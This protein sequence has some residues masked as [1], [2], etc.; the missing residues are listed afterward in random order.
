MNKNFTCSQNLPLETYRRQF[1][2]VIRQRLQFC[3]AAS[4]I[5]TYGLPRYQDFLALWKDADA[6]LPIL[7]E[8]KE[9][10][11]AVE[12]KLLPCSSCAARRTE[13]CLTKL[14]D[15]IAQNLVIENPRD[16]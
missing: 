8:A 16:H 5:R 13:V 6:D 7:V 1:P 10:V 11:R 2:S 12:V 9:R 3:G 14:L 4:L 15:S